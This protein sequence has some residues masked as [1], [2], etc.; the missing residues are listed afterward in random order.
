MG[1]RL[2]L[3][4]C[5]VEVEVATE[6]LITALA[7]ENHL[8]P[9]GLDL[10]RHEKHGGGGSNAGGVERLNVVYYVSDGVNPFLRRK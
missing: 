5:L 10:T 9:Q 7:T 6:D 1:S 4:G 3:I 8:D 2:Y